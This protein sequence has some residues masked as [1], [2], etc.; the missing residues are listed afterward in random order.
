[1]NDRSGLLTLATYLTAAAAIAV[2]ACLGIFKYGVPSP[3]QGMDTIPADPV[4]EFAVA[5]LDLAP[6]GSP[7]A[8]SGFDQHRV[9]ILESMLADKTRRLQE[10]SQLLALQQQEYENL[11]RRYDDAMMVAFESLSQP[12]KAPAA[13]ESAANSDS[14]SPDDQSR[15]EA[16][17]AMARAVHETTVSDLET[18]QDELTRAYEELGHTKE[19]A[20]RESTTRLREALALEAATADVLL[21]IGKDAVPA[22]KEALTHD[23]PIVRRWAA[24]ALGAI[25]TDAGDAVLALTEALADADPGVRRAAKAAL[26]AIER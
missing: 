10:L 13:G 4:P 8:A 3:L 2:V 1:M 26:D 25:G 19:E 6:Q 12:S 15:L 20:G 22:L 17:L 9:R 16:Q 24:T 7:S 18:L 11:K 23:S 21:R 5:H 14:S